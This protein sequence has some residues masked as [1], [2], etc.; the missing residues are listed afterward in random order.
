MSDRIAFTGK[1]EAEGRRL[2][3]E[4]VLA[5][6]RTWRD[7]EWLEIDPAALVAADASS[8]FAS[9]EH[10]DGKVLGDV[11]TGSLSV[12]RTDTGFTYETG[13][14]PN[15]SYAND[16]LEL[17]RLG[18]VK[19]TSFEIEGIRSKFSTDPDGKRVRRLTSIERFRQVGPVRDPAFTNS[20]TA[21]F[22]KESTVTNIIDEPKVEPK[23]D[24]APVV[25]FAKVTD[26]KSDTYRTAEAFAKQQD[27]A[28]LEQAM[29]NLIAGGIDTAPRQETYDAFA[30]VYDDRKKADAS[31]RERAERILLGQQLRTGQG[32]KAPVQVGAPGSEDYRQAFGKYLR[33]GNPQ[34]MEQ[35]AQSV[36]GDG[37]Q[38]GFLVPDGFLARV[39]ERL[40]A[41]G[42]IAK[43][44]EEL[45]TAT[46]ESLRWSSNDDTGNSAGIAAEGAAVASG[47]ADLVFDGI[48]LGS[49]EYDATGTGNLP[50]RV[51]KTLLQD[52]AYNVEAFLERKLSQRIGRK[53]AVDFATGVGGTQ[54]V[55]LLSKSTDAMT[56]T[57]VSLAL[58]EHVLQ[59]DAEY[60]DMGN[61][62]WILSDTT[63]LKIWQSQDTTNRPMIIP[64]EGIDGTPAQLLWGYPYQVDNGAG[65]LVAF[66]D[67]KEGYIIRRVRGVEVLVDPY[68]QNAARQVAY[69]AWARAD[70]NINDAFA[71][72]VSTWASVSADT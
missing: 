56:A 7:G 50:V 52:A 24:P 71:Y 3:G 16:A 35:F 48:E 43:H 2:R 66:G 15:T 46:G 70:A 68:T 58:P 5:G 18:L 53:Q 40:K 45:V 25:T 32:P 8:V 63:L 19:G 20:Y 28:G 22:S 11:A 62:R 4:V 1:V 47:G 72:S 54:P 13:E 9:W 65:N 57:A 60:R 6:S 49:F 59:V 67:I 33:T 14:L 64:G 17:V 27:I 41:Y 39:T 38:G 69:H 42:G 29:A 37:T 31:A 36:A 30:A 26:D 10:D 12:Q 34:L 23:A 51:S 61:C 55:G 21:A 44:A